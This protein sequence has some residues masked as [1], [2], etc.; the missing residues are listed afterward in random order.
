MALPGFVDTVGTEFGEVDNPDYG[1]YTEPGWNKGAFGDPL[2]GWENQGFALPTKVLKPYG[3]GSKDFASKFNQNYEIQAYSPATG[4]VV[5]G[6]LKDV[7]P[8]PGADA[9]IDMLSGSRSALGLERNFKGSVQYRIVPKGTPTPESASLASANLSG[10]PTPTGVQLG[11]PAA[12]TA[13]TTAATVP[14][15]TTPAATTPAATTPAATT[16]AA[17]TG[18]PVLA[19]RIKALKAAMGFSDTSPAATASDSGY[20]G[21]NLAS[22][23]STGGGTGI[24]YGLIDAIRRNRAAQ[25][26]QMQEALKGGMQLGGQFAAAGGKFYGQLTNANP[27]FNQDWAN[28]QAQAAGFADYAAMQRAGAV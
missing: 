6:P 26:L 4:K 8:A 24:N 17:A 16:A 23:G 2:T 27:V 10:S 25:S 21:L 28:Q 22:L 9:G 11:Y 14:A 5:T 3:Y 15:A 13:A 12:T 20:S 1:G 7:G 18:D 19:Q